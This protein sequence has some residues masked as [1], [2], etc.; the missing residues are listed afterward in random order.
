MKKLFCLPFSLLLVLVTTFYTPIKAQQPIQLKFGGYMQGLVQIAEKN[1][2]TSVGKP[3]LE[4]QKPFSRLGLR[5]GYFKMNAT[6]SDFVAEAML[7]VTDKEIGVFKAYINWAPQ[8]AKNHSLYL[9]LN[10]VPFGCELGLSSQLRETFERATYYADMFPG[11]TDMGIY[12][13]YSRVFREGRINKLNIDLGLTSGNAQHGMR[14]AIPDAVARIA[15]GLIGNNSL[16][17]YGLSTYI[18]YATAM[19]K[20]ISK[21]IYMSAYLDH[22]YNLVDGTLKFR[23]ELLGGWQAGTPKKNIA[24]G[25]NSPEKAGV[26]NYILIERPFIGAMATTIFRFSKLPIEGVLKYDYYNRNLNLEKRLNMPKS[27]ETLVFASEGVSHKGVVGINSYFYNNHVRLSAH[28]DINFKQVGQYSNP[29][30]KDSK[31][32]VGW[33]SHDDILTL[34]MQFSF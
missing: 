20:Q 9:G 17:Y 6:Y 31:L 25:S 4:R 33:L 30:E 18:G 13:K 22:Q 24:I 7:R 12:Y 16:Q 10:T 27:Q 29:Y 26:D 1:A 8:K 2:T 3:P 23:A 15:I 34:G 19:G 21:R 28:Y 32:N 5:R 11:D 14:K